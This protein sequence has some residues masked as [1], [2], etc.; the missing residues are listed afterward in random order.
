MITN[1]LVIPLAKR[2]CIINKVGRNSRMEEVSSVPCA[3]AHKNDKVFTI[4][5]ES[6]RF[7]KYR[8]VD[9]NMDV[10]PTNLRRHVIHIN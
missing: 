8:T 1:N 4:V 3:H 9:W 10:L 2:I 7:Y 5:F 6:S